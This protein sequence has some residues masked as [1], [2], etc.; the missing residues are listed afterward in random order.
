MVWDSF[1]SLIPV[2][3]GS[4]EDA[5][6][7]MKN[8]TLVECKNGERNLCYLL[9]KRSEKVVSVG[10][11]G[12]CVWRVFFFSEKDKCEFIGLGSYKE[13][14]IEYGLVEELFY[15]QIRLPA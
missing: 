3:P 11:A 15:Y 9:H 7:R 14:E 1:T 10:K 6:R 2:V 5:K 4:V 8:S 13:R 12:E